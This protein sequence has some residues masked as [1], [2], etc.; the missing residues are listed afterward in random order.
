MYPSSIPS[1]YFKDGIDKEHVGLVFARLV[2][3]YILAGLHAALSHFSCIIQ[4]IF[5]Y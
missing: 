3:F 2:N 5:K 1:R 4:S